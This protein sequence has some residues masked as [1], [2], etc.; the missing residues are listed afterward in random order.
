MT[1]SANP[2]PNPNPNPTAADAPARALSRVYIAA[3]LDGYIAREDGSLDWLMQAN[4]AVPEGEDCGYAQFMAGVDAIVMGRATFETIAAFA[5][6]P[7]GDTP[8]IVMSRSGWRA[9]VIA[10]ASI[11]VSD[12]TPDALL[13]RL[14]AAGLARVYL[15]GGRLIQ[16]FLEAGV[17]D[18]ITV[19]TIPRLL[20]RGRPLFGALA[21]DVPLVLV[22]SRSWP[23]GFV[24][25]TWRVGAQA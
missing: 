24:Q 22:G 21:G 20:G 13:R 7:Y 23:F 19:T 3:S 8:V 4:A 11:S 2:N 25:S 1:P 12:E 9:P 14:G 6:W 15:D 18:E 10:G 17:V 5:Q 16:S